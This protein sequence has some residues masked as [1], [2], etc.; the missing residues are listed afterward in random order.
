MDIMVSIC[1]YV[2]SILI[3][4]G[5]RIQV[6]EIHL[7]CR[8]RKL[9]DLILCSWREKEDFLPLSS[10]CPAHPE[11]AGTRLSHVLSVRK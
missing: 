5:N 7:N 8:K 4:L 10:L 1:I 11:S 2:F 9:T 3:K 6:K